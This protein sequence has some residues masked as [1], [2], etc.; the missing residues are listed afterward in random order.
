LN[1]LN[2]GDD[3]CGDGDAIEILFETDNAALARA[4]NLK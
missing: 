4:N 3:G 1:E 2:D